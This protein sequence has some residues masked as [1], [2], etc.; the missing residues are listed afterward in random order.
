VVLIVSFKLQTSDFKLQTSDTIMPPPTLFAC[1]Y[2][3]RAAPRSDALAAVALEFSSRIEARG[4]RLVLC[5]VSGLERLFGDAQAIGVAL[6]RAAIRRG[7]AARVAVA[8]TRVAAWI[9]ATARP[10]LT[11]VRPGAEA[12]ALAPLAVET[13]GALGEAGSRPDDASEIP[14]GRARRRRGPARHYRLAPAPAAETRG[15]AH[16]EAGVEAGFSRPDSV[17]VLGRVQPSAQRPTPIPRQARDGLS[18]SKASALSDLPSLLATLTRWGVRTLGELAALPPSALAARVGTAGPA[19]CR[20]ARGEDPRPLVPDPE[21]RRFEASLDLEWPIEALEPLSFVLAR[22][23]EPLSADL[24]RADR[25]AVALALD[26]RLV[27]RETWTRTL[28]LP[29]P[30]RDPR[31]LRTLLLLDLESHPPPAGIDRVAIEATPSPGRIVQYSLIEHPLP[32]PEQLSTLMARLTALMGEGRSGVPALVDSHRPGAFEVRALGDGRW[33]MG[34]AVASAQRPAPST[35]NGAVASAQRPAPSTPNGAVASAQRPA[36]SAQ[37][38]PGVLRRFRVPVVATVVALD[39]GRPVRVTTGRQS[40][41]AGRVEQAAGP[42][43]TSGEWW[44]PSAWDRDEWDVVVAGGTVY[45]LS[46]DRARGTWVVEG[47]VD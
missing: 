15:E 16:V 38:V 21:P 5:D 31:V 42:W 20:L 22:L 35:P 4:E 23:V 32:S 44:R 9:I 1:L 3:P 33:A 30:I 47:I 13:L 37:C 29:A 11:V 36:P 6:G 10:G 28:D 39:E 18:L 41:P 25:G 40:L 27:T 26:L 2:L 14:R 7:L 43:R 8:G 34:K 24:E 45:R 19:L 12:A 46:R 17:S